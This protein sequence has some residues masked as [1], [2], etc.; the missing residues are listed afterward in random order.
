MQIKE[1]VEDSKKELRVN[2]LHFIW[3]TRN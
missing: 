2:R 3:E 1:N